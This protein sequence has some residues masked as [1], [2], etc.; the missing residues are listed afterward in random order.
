M[1]IKGRAKYRFNI[2]ADNSGEYR[3]QLLG[4]NGRSVAASGEG[5]KRPGACRK[6]VLSL[7]TFVGQAAVTEGPHVVP[8]MNRRRKKKA[9]K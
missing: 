7:M 1:A 6:A 3:W 2:Y 8:A 4:R 9:V 5:Y